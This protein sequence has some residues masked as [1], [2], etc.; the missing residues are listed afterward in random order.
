MEDGQA[1]FDKLST[2]VSQFLQGEISYLGMI[3]QDAILE[4]TIRQQRVVSLS[5]PTAKS[6]KAFSVLTANL[7]N[8]E[9]EPYVMP[10]GIG[11]LLANFIKK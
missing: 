8:H 9:H 10:K 11:Q 6:A 1:V 3:P 4:R 5:M 2:V 7:L